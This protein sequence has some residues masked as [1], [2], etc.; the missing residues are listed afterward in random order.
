MKGISINRNSSGIHK[1]E[2]EGRLARW[3]LSL[4]LHFCKGSVQGI[5]VCNWILSFVNW[6]G[7]IVL[8]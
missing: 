8:Y 1:L 4:Q 3:S 5:P 7:V 2:L 6:A